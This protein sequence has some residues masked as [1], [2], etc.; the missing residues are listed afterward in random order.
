MIF[1]NCILEL[2]PWINQLLLPVQY[3]I[4]NQIYVGTKFEDAAYYCNVL[5]EE[6]AVMEQKINLN[7]CIHIL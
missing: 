4:Q 7:E 3:L 2:C 5:Y 6:V 1:G